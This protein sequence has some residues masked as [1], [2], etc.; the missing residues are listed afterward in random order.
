MKKINDFI[1][2][3]AQTEY[4]CELIGSGEHNKENEGLPIT[5]TVFVDRED[6][7]CFERYAIDVADDIFSHCCGGNVEY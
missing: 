3:S 1:N 2:E 4:R 6:V 7:K 5:V